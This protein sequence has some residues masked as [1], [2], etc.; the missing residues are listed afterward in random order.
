MLK[1][2]VVIALSAV[3]LV[4]SLCRAADAKPVKSALDRMPVTEITVF[5]DGHAFALHAG[6]LPVDDSGKAVMDYLPAPVLGT[7]WPFC[8]DREVK[9]SAVTAGQRKIGVE[10]TAL[11]LPELLEANVGG[12]ALVSELLPAAG[13]EGA[14]VTYRATILGV[15][16]QSGEELEATSPPNTG[17]RLP[18]KGS[19]AL[20]KTAE[21][22][23]AVAISRIQDLTFPNPSIRPALE[24]EE[25]R[26]FLEL[27][28]DWPGGKVR[29]AV[30]VGLLYLQK[31]VR[32]IPN[33]KVDLDGKGKARVVLQATV[34]N[35]LVDLSDVTANLVIGVPSFA[36]RETVDPMALQQTA[37]QLSQYFREDSRTASGF[38]NAIMSQSVRM[39]ESPAAAAGG[40][41]TIDLGPEVA[42][43]EKSEDLY[44]F[45][46]KHLTLAK[47]QRKVFPVAE[48]KL[49]YED[50]YSLEMPLL[51]PPEALRQIGG[52]RQTEMARIMATPRAMHKVRL[53]NKSPHPLTT[54]PA[55]ILRE[56]KVLAQ[57]MMTYTAIGAASDLPLT[58]AV[59]IKVKKEEKEVKRTPKALR[60]DG[61]DLT[62][63]D[64]SGRITLTNFDGKPVKIEVVRSILGNNIQAGNGGKA[65][66]ISPY[67]FLL[68]P[69]AWSSPSV[70]PWWTWYSWPYWWFHL[71]GM[72]RITW[73][74]DLAPGKPLDLDYSWS[75][76][77]G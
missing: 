73:T 15:P 56:G 27:S 30:E 37:A 50:I 72:G 8:S 65:E 1:F 32:W 34:I 22:V 77:A 75:W 70:P 47:G 16:A 67:D 36:F 13:K 61:N 18:Q 20:L 6:K 9:L 74:V 24:R 76:Y 21:G 68:S 35:E 41:A 10:R 58:T 66:L 51:P 17:E 54:A 46:V 3:V 31:G 19:L 38:S 14:Y 64:W 59:N 62:L 12:E 53:Q 39:A 40:R 25:F 71:N 2:R 28:F 63:I 29:P 49:D 52:S 33:Y 60:W 45:T 44:V 4:P 26:N 48:F 69:D 57:G 7:F 43:S 23:K 55:L 42:G 5:K 11:N